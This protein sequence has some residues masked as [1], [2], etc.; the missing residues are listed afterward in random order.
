MARLRRTW[1][2]DW[3][4]HPLLGGRD[5]PLCDVRNYFGEKIAL[6]FAWVEHYTKRLR[7][8]A[9]V[10]LIFFI[11]ST[12]L[13]DGG[14]KYMLL[15]AFGQALLEDPSK[16]AGLRVYGMPWMPRRVARAV[17]AR[18]AARRRRGA[19]YD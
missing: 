8:P 17:L 2:F 7:A 9:A 12:L 5:Q 10:G 15:L 16:A 6:Y 11:I 3:G 4:R 18:T 1:V 14:P 19:I 13:D